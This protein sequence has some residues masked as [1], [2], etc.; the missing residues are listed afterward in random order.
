ME[1][2]KLIVSTAFAIESYTIYKD[3]CDWVINAATE[4]AEKTEN[5]VLVGF[6]KNGYNKVKEIG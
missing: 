6:S 2:K 1:P 4:R 5:I 3:M